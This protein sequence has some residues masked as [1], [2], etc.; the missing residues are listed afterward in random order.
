MF[1]L[2]D[3]DHLVAQT[4]C[5]IAIETGAMKGITIIVGTEKEILIEDTETIKVTC[6]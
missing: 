4:Q 5:M 3:Q 2:I 1:L 6:R